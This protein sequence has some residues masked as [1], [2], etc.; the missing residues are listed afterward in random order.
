MRLTTSV[1]IDIAR[2]REQVFDFACAAETYVKLFRPRGPVA[3]VVAAEMVD[4]AKLATGARRRMTLSDGAV[5][6]EE[7]TAFD[8]PMRHAYRWSGGLRA[9]GKFLV[10]VGEGEWTFAARDGRTRIDWSYTFELT[11]P[12][13]YPAAAFMLGQ[14]RRWMEQQLSAIDAALTK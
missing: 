7:V 11:T 12:L 3:G 5:L 1:S 10:R 2:P 14:F 8:R 4:G 6:I 13:V 9:P